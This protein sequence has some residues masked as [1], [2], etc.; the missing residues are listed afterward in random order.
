[1]FLFFSAVID[2]SV[3]ITYLVSY[4]RSLFQPF[5]VRE[6]KEI[7]VAKHN[8]LPGARLLSAE[9]CAVARE[10]LTIQTICSGVRAT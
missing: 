9:I 5:A 4:K 1:M 10:L 6:N 3:D 7:P 2:Y 8:P